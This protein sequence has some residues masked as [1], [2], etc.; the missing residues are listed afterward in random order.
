[1]SDQFGVSQGQTGGGVG[2]PGGRKVR[3]AS[4]EIHLGVMIAAG[5]Q[6][7]G[8]KGAAT[9]AGVGVATTLCVVVVRLNGG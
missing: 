2:H 1:M 9:G 4:G 5:E 3:S 8:A 7:E 6:D